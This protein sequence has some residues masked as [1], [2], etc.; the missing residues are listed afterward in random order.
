MTSY[1]ANDKKNEI[2]ASLVNDIDANK[3]LIYESNI[4]INSDFSI[5]LLDKL[6]FSWPN[7]D[8]NYVKKY[9]TYL[10]DIYFLQ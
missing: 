2:I 7:I 10:F 4:K 8:E 6:D 9:I 5:A 1:L 3:K